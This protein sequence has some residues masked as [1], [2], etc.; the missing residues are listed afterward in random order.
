M[1]AVVTELPVS[2]VATPSVFNS[3]TYQVG[4][5]LGLSCQAQG[6]Y[7]PLHYSWNSTCESPCFVSMQTTSFIRKNALHSVDS[8]NHT[9]SVLDY[10]GRTGDA[11]VQLLV[12]GMYGTRYKMSIL[13]KLSHR[14][15][16]YATITYAWNRPILF[17][18]VAFYKLKHQLLRYHT[19]KPVLINNHLI[20]QITLYN[21]PACRITSSTNTNLVHHQPAISV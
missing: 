7:P 6:A 13:L 4:S 16:N 17:I 18:F 2:I 10:V 3:G 8:G 12:S 15:A 21:M 20:W 1:F 5:S 9:C 11:T 19:V 14:L